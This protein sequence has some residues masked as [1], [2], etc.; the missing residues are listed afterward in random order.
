LRRLDHEL[1]AECRDL[2]GLHET[3]LAYFV[4]HARRLSGAVGHWLT[5]QE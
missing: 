1:I 5:N 3:G 4:V 2:D